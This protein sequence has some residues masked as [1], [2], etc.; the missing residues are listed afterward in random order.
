MFDISIPISELEF[1]GRGHVIALSL[2]LTPALP[3]KG[4]SR[5]ARPLFFTHCVRATHVFVPGP[6]PSYIP[7]PLSSLYS[8]AP[9]LPIFSA[10]GPIF[11]A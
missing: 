7:R 11:G 2:Q 1:I 6:C 5:T 9:A 8:Q 10:Y 3:T 4:R